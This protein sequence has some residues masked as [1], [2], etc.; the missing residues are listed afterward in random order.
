MGEREQGE[1]KGWGVAVAEDVDIA[2]FPP[3]YL[4]V[5]ALFLQSGV[6]SPVNS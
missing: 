3:S 5:Q 4:M 2:H 1:R 6:F